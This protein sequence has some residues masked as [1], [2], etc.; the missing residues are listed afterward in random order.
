MSAIEV[1]EVYQVIRR[2]VP[3]VRAIEAVAKLRAAEIAPVDESLALE[4]AEIALEHGLAMA[5]AIVYATARRAAARWI[6]ADADFE[7]LPGAEVIR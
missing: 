6:T 2:D 5:D 7:G 4:A 1:S 3:E